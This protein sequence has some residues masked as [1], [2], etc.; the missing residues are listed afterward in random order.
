MR[1][2]FLIFVLEIINRELGKFILN[3]W[4]SL[5]LA[6]EVQGVYSELTK[7]AAKNAEKVFMSFN[8]PVHAIKA[9]I[10]NDYVSYNS[11]A[12]EGELVNAKL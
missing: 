3:K 7:K 9:P 5:E 12:N 6:E 11:Y 8:V 10:A 4:I 1:E 2:Y